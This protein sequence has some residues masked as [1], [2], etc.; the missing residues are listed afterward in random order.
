MTKN[1]VIFSITLG[2]IYVIIII[3]KVGKLVKVKLKKALIK[4]LKF[5][6]KVKFIPLNCDDFYPDLK[7]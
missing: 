5:K 7:I 6:L 3:K 2:C 4:L 1:L